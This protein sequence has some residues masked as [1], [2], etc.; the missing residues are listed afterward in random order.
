[1]RCD[2]VAGGWLS[3][4]PTLDC[5]P[6]RAA[7]TA[8]DSGRL[9]SEHHA[10]GV[11]REAGHGGF[12]PSSL[13]GAFF[14]ST[15]TCLRTSLNHHHDAERRVAIDPY[16]LIVQQD[17]PVGANALVDGGVN[18]HRS[19]WSVANGL[20]GAR[21][22]DRSRALPTMRRGGDRLKTSVKHTAN[23]HGDPVSVGRGT[24][25][26]CH[27]YWSNFRFRFWPRFGA[28]SR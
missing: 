27:R 21:P 23:V 14:A 2:Y 20:G 9:Q 28:K 18:G 19:K 3:D 6:I 10:N 8:V 12:S 13:Q 17:S 4:R 22:P 24:R 25:W 15:G 26:V 5:E 11:L 1:M 7:L 16:R